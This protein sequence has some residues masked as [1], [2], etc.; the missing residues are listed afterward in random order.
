MEALEGATGTSA[1]T[2]RYYISQGLVPPALTV[3]RTA[4]YGEDHLV[5][6]RRIAAAKDQGLSLEQ[7]KQQLHPPTGTPAAWPSQGL[8]AMHLLDGV[9][10]LVRADLPLWQRNQMEKALVPFVAAFTRKTS[11]EG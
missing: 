6:L 4:S 8:R 1:R 9:T 7:I 2:I 10:L 3:G 5:A 11:E